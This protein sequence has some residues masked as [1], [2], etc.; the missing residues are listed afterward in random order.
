MKEYPVL[1]LSHGAPDLPLT[2]H[3]AREAWQ[4]IGRSLPRPEGIIVISAHWL[5]NRLTI[6]GS[7][8]YTTI[9]DFSGFPE[10]LYQ[11]SYPA[12]GSRELA[13]SLREQFE[14]ENIPADIDIRRGLDH[15]AWVPLLLLY[16]QADIPVI[17]ISLPMNAS[18]P[19]LEE[20]GKV[21]AKQRRSNLI[22]CSGAVT[23]NLR[24]LAPE[25]TPP[26]DWAVRFTDWVKERLL[27]DDGKGLQQFRSAPYMRLAHPTDEHFL[28]IFVA[29]GAAHGQPVELLHESFSYG[30]LSM[31]V[32]SF[33]AEATPP[34]IH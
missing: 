2:E 20:I 13:E 8:S 12:L 5:T 6:S 29:L 18:I 19:E 22:V 4:R 26:A 27:Q 3:P 31:A 30:N 7:H 24:A 23:H 34:A 32:F 28:P 15:G 25:G 16:P 10:E 14:H 21:L 17:Q 1:F 33:H 11:L 9:H